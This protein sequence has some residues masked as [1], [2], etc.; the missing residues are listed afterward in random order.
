MNREVL[1]IALPNIVSN[2]TV[3]LMG[4]VSTAIAGR[5]AGADSAI[6]IGQLA[7]GVSIFNMIYWNCSF[8]RMGTS[9][10]TAQAYGAGDFAETTKMLFRSLAV[11]FLLGFTLLLL[12]EPMATG[13]VELMG[14]SAISLEYVR[15]R[16]WAV[17]AGILLFGFHGWFTGMQNGTYSMSIA[18][19]VNVIHM[20][21]SYYF[22]IVA[23]YG[24]VGIAYGSIVAQWS[25]VAVATAILLLKFS[26]R[27]VPVSL[28]EVCDIKVILKFFSVNRDIMLR[29]FCI[30][31]VYTFFTRASAQFGDPNLLATNTLL[32][33]LFT[34]YSYM[35]DGFAFAAEALTG[36]FIGAKDRAS[37]K[38]AISRCIIW[39]LVV[40]VTYVVI[41]LI[42]WRDLLGVLMGSNGDIA[43]ILSYAEQYIWWLIVIPIFGAFPFLMDG[44]M[45]GAGYTG[46]MRNAMFLST[47]SY[48]AIYFVLEPYI[49][50]NALWLAFLMFMCL[51]G[52]L[53][54]LMTSR[55]NVL[56]N[57]SFEQSQ[58]EAE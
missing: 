55:L 50:N 16:L 31:A 15:A 4:I 34:L 32:L 27:L 56:Y 24:V 47:I 52:L 22:A 37:L 45:V 40:S 10:L 38:L 42:F 28:R 12:K 33:Q 49:G 39:S 46:V 2:V 58:H 41:Y 57:V 1:R 53:Q 11:S 20:L 35:T 30:V 17:P 13:A 19:S 14:G 5:C 6:M 44:I 3:P 23:G 51:R 48:F 43:M 8:I 7:I 54:Y 9:G 29:T 18:L 25:G 26:K 36:R 21:S